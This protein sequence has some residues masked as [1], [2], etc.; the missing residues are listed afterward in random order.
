MKRHKQAN[1]ELLRILCALMVIA[2]HMIAQSNILDNCSIGN[3]TFAVFF[4]AGGRLACSV[5]VIIGAYFLVDIPF[6]SY[7]ILQ[8]FVKTVITVAVIDVALFV[9]ARDTVQSMSIVEL[10]IQI[11]PF[12]GQPY[13][14]VVAYICMLVLSPILNYI[15]NENR[16]QNYKCLLIVLSLCSVVVGSIPLIFKFSPF[17][18][19]SLWFCFLYILT[20]ELKHRGIFN[21]V[22]KWTWAF[23]FI[24]CYFSACGI[25]LVCNQLKANWEYAWILRF[26]Y[27]STYQSI[28]AFI[29]AISLFGLFLSINISNCKVSS[30]IEKISAHT[31]GIFLIHQVPLLWVNGWIWN[32]VF[33]IQQYAYQPYFPLYCFGVLLICFFICFC[34]DVLL[35]KLYILFNRITKIPQLAERLDQ[36]IGVA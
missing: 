15:V 32:R 9:F 24:V 28:F 36:Y 34:V 17:A 35:E 12:L 4:H 21:I 31:F 30:I 3:Y 6:H 26:F 20:G 27:I 5:F 23:L 14:F 11:F 8:L 33:H 2:F 7:R 19:D 18:N 10:V 29:A 25:C 13:W 22:S 16:I 1:L